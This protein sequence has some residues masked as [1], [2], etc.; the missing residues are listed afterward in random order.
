MLALFGLWLTLKQLKAIKTEAEAQKAAIEAVQFKVASFDTAQECQIARSLIQKIQSH[1]QSRAW[2]E[3][4]TAYE[5]LVESFLRL[6]HSNSAIHIDDRALLIKLTKNMADICEGIRK[7]QLVSGQAVI[8]R[9]QDQAIRD[10][11][12]IMTKITFSVARDI[13]K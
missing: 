13:Q 11:S 1:L 3:V 7:R 8:L 5:K 6:S 12:D 9:G 2:P 4:L 10:F